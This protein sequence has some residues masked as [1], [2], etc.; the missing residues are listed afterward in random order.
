MHDLV[1]FGLAAIVGLSVVAIIWVILKP[2]TKQ[3][4]NCKKVFSMK[5][6]GEL[7][8]MHVIHHKFFEWEYEDRCKWCGHSVWKTHSNMPPNVTRGNL[9]GF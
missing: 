2:I 4:R 3:C 8:N 6:T 5:V 7:R 1:N 9:A